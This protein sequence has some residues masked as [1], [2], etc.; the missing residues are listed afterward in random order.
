MTGEQLRAL[1]AARGGGSPPGVAGAAAPAQAVGG[2]GD[3]MHTGLTYIWLFIDTGEGVT[4]GPPLRALGQPATAPCSP[5][6]KDRAS[7]RS[8]RVR[9]DRAAP[10]RLKEE[11]GAGR[12]PRS[13]L[14][15]DGGQH[16]RLPP[17]G[18]APAGPSRSLWEGALLCLHAL[19]S[20]V[21][22]VRW[23]DR[24][25]PCESSHQLRSVVSPKP[26]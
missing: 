26:A 5:G 2:E 19:T 20:P 3:S 13:A 7:S 4:G 21:H 11:A 12:R 24:Q 15:P 8:P 16:P 25:T 14:V 1:G 9:T 17:G 10:L 22:R 6:P 18:Q 23:Q